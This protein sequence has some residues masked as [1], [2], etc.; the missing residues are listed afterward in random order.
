MTAAAKGR[1]ENQH[2]S[3]FV[4]R[5]LQVELAALAQRNGRSF[6]AEARIALHDHVSANLA[7]DGK[8][9]EDSV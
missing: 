1:V 6:S 5:W 2:V 7:T 8:E 9:D 3:M 4:P